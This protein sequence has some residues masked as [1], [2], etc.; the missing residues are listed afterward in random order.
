IPAVELRTAE[1]SL[2]D[3]INAL[4]DARHQ[5]SDLPRAPILVFTSWTSSGGWWWVE[6]DPNVL[7]P[8][9]E[10]RG[11]THLQ[12]VSNVSS[13]TIQCHALEYGLV[14]PGIPVHT[15]IQQADSS[16]SCTYT[17]TWI[18]RLVQSRFALS[19]FY[20]L[21]LHSR[22][23]TGL[24]CFKVVIHCFIDGK[25]H[26]I[27]GIRASSNNRAQMVLNLFCKAVNRYGLP[28]QV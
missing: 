10:L 11:P 20:P 21:A 28:S 18:S 7:A 5:S 1:Q 9:L 14:E 8:A 26:L 15:D 16:V 25:S 2:A 23:N 24:I 3:M 22:V 12:N 27:T 19:L 17:S 13:R 6:I 4:N